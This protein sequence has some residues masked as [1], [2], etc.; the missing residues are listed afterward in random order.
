MTPSAQQKIVIPLIKDFMKSRGFKY[1][2][3][4]EKEFTKILDFGSIRISLFFSKYRSSSNSLFRIN[5]GAVE[6]IIIHKVGL[7]NNELESYKTGENTLFTIK[8]S[9]TFNPYGGVITVGNPNSKLRKKI[10]NEKDALEFANFFKDYV[11]NQGITFIEKYSYM[12]NALEKINELES[13]G[14]KYYSKYIL[15]GADKFFRVL[16]IS[17]LCN[18]P[19]YGKKKDNIDTIFNN[20]KLVTWKP[21]YERLNTELDKIVPIY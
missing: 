4:Y 9:S 18:D 15:G 2:A 6:N 14:D 8:D 1:S 10:E 19:D 3:P 13:N 11:L 5:Y 17:K 12:P 21:Y 20:P 16:L 7:A